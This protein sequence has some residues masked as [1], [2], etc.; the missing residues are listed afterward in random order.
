MFFL[1]IRST[2]CSLESISTAFIPGVDILQGEE[3]FRFQL[4]LHG[5][6]RSSSRI[7][8]VMVNQDIAKSTNSDIYVTVVSEFD[9]SYCVSLYP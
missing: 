3:S 8:L 6:T 1:M 2:N 9:R 7:A 4:P 5:D